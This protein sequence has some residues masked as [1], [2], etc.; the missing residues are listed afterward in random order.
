M[1]HSGVDGGRFPRF[2]KVI[3]VAD[4]VESVRLM[5]EDEA[6]FIRRWKL[7]VGFVLKRLPL[8]TGRMHRSLGDGLMIEFTDPQGCIRAALAMQGWFME[9]NRGLPPEQQVH[10]RIG[11]HIGD[12]VADEYD[13]YGTDVNLAARIATLAGPGEI[14]ISGAL[15][16]RVRGELNA[17]L[18]DL[19]ACH[20]K[21]V[22]LPVR[23][24]RVGFTGPAPVM[25]AVG[26]TRAT[27]RASVAVLP[28]ETSDAPGGSGS[29]GQAAADEA[30]AALS[31]SDG[32]QVTS[33]LST[34]A[35]RQVRPSLD[36]IRRHLGSRYVLSGH[37]REIG[38]QLAVFAELTDTHSGH[39]VWADS[40][41]GRLPDLLT[42]GTTFLATLAPS[43]NA[44]V[45]A[46]EVDR[47]E[48]LPLPAL[49]GYALLLTS[50]AVMHRLGRAD[51]DRARLM[52][53]HL[54]ERD[55]RHPAAHA[56]LAHWHVLGVL[57]GWLGAED[58]LQPATAHI[59][60]ALQCDPQAPIVLCMAGHVALHLARDLRGAGEYFVQALG[61]RPDDPLAHLLQGELFAWRG[62]GQRAR[63]A[64]DAALR[65]MPPLAL[66]YWY[67]AGAALAC[68]ADGALPQAV[69]AAE[70]SLRANRRFVP[71]YCTLAAAQFEIGD[72]QEARET[73]DRLQDAQP[74]FSVAGY[75][76]RTPAQGLVASRLAKALQG[77]AAGA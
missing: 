35:L 75:L 30:V 44:A 10:L 49:E 39:I 53:E 25:P 20:L 62:Q 77:A 68:W 27:M 42:G 47:A 12:F 6:E 34:V 70:Q 11:A 8:D 36:E 17:Q 55:R 29:L 23:A 69:A 22:K 66:R 21:H 46:N 76:Q 18:E 2:T 43:V 4:V 33:R 60:S 31:R 61:S 67:D 56:W 72:I 38:G 65:L 59:Q 15:R 16:E 37:A 32:L 41:K 73:L 28:F 74:R 24:Y 50:I 58:A 57:Q 26:P 9:G 5:E 51:L 1:P 7:F 13:I 64:C 14:V 54:A 71:A 3:A 19:G 48:G 52:L 45:M 63:A 40:F